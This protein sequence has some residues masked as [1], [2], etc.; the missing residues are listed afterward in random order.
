MKLVTRL[1]QWKI[2]TTQKKRAEQ[3]PVP[4]AAMKNEFSSYCF[5]AD[6]VAVTD[7]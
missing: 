1:Y 7:I 5:I 3:F 4:H 2:W 6:T